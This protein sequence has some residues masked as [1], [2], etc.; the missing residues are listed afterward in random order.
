MAWYD[1]AEQEEYDPKPGFVFT[2][3]HNIWCFGKVMYDMMTLAERGELYDKIGVGGCKNAADVDSGYSGGFKPNDEVVYSEDVYYENGEHALDE[4]T[5]RRKPEYSPGLRKLIRQCLEVNMR[6][7][8]TPEE[9]LDATNKGLAAA[10][11]TARQQHGADAPRAERLFYRENQINRMAP[12]SPK[13]EPNTNMYRRLTEPVDDEWTPLNL[14]RH[15]N[16]YYFRQRE[17][18]AQNER[19]LVLLRL[20]NKALSTARVDTLGLD[21]KFLAQDHHQ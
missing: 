17:R 9:L 10:L 14:P 19:E 16:P 3:A 21:K 4:I 11:A 12:G 5:T 18:G 6:Y 8:P 7:R 1:A 13:W 2:Q 20:L 15:W